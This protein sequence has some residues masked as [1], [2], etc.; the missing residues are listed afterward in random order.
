MI[1]D[2]FPKKFNN[3]YTEKSP[4]EDSY[5]IFIREKSVLLKERGGEISYPRF[6][7]IPDG[8]EVTYLFSIDEENF[9]LAESDCADSLLQKGYEFCDSAN[10]RRLS[11]KYMS[12]AGITAF[13]LGNWYKNNCFCGR[14]GEKLSHDSD[15]RMLRC[16]ACGNMVYPKISPAVIVGVTN[17]DKLLMAKYKGREH[18]PRYALI[19]GFAEIG[20]PIEDAVRREVMEEVGLRV[21]NI[22]YYKS[23]PWSFTDTMLMGFYC[24]VDG[25]DTVTVDKSELALAEWVSREDMGNIINDGITLTYEMITRFK[26]NLI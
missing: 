19:A 23:Q 22:R 14:C 3:H 7:E 25:Y 4:E 17:G 6:E 1:H 15:E 13:Q 20:E 24:E 8:T 2:I 21:K 26:E 12:F 16:D 9:F 5:I 10:F 11:P 18:L